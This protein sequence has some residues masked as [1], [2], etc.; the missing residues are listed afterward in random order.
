MAPAI[1]IASTI[2]RDIVVTPCL[3]LETKCEPKGSMAPAVAFSRRRFCLEMQKPWNAAAARWR[4][5]IRLSGG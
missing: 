1:P 4:P 2:R 3:L 5:G